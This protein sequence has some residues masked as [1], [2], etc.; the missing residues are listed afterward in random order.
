MK[1]LFQTAE[2]KH[3]NDVVYATLAHIKVHTHY[4]EE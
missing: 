2:V 3:Q 4:Y 1:N